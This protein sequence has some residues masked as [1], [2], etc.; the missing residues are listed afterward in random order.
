M[1]I[2]QDVVTFFTVFDVY[3]SGFFGKTKI[4]I[5]LY[6]GNLQKSTRLLLGAF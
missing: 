2:L 1:V 3:V 6:H 4:G 5:V